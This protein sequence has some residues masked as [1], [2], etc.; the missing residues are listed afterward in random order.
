MPVQDDA[1]ERELVRMFNLI[2]ERS[3]QRSGVDAYL[4]V[5]VD[6]RHFRIEV[7][8]KSTTGTSVSTARDV[9][10]EHIGKW[11]KKFFVI[12]FYTK[13][14]QPELRQCLCLSPADMEPWIASIESRIAVDFKL[15]QI[16]SSKLTM[17]DLFLLIGEKTHYTIE[18]AKELHKRQWNAAQYREARDVSIGRR[19]LISPGRMLQI[20]QL[21]SQYIAERGATLNNPHIEKTF[22]KSFFGTVR[23][24]SESNWAAAVRQLAVNF[25]RSNPRHAAAVESI[26]PQP[27]S[28]AV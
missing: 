11:R 2:W 25:I 27:T 16:A 22:L 13:E 6:N 1:R 17:D 10:I 12:G 3:H 18:D 21:R 15:A 9:G 24:V 20:L 14:A 8:V 26:D 7:E 19:K 5:A 23:E 4:D 28:G